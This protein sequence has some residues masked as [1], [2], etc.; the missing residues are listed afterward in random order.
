[1]LLAPMVI[2]GKK[3][4][5]LAL[6]DVTEWRSIQNA[7][8]N[9]HM[10]LEQSYA[11]T[12][13][14]WGRAMELRDFETQ[15]HMKRVTDATVNLALSMGVSMEEI[16]HI[17]HGAVLHDIGKFAIPDA[18]LLKPA[19]LTPDEWIIMKR[20][21]VYAYELLKPVNYLT[22]SLPIPYSHHEKWDG[23]GYPQALH[24]TQIP[25][26]ARIFAVVDVWDALRSDRPY[27]DGWQDE[28]VRAY[29]KENSGSHFDPEVVDCF[30]SNF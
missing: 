7:L 25:L 30:L 9:T 28:R 29:I 15:G 2:L 5:H 22:R 3:F 4:L 8:I 12:L 20:H 14:G 6:R 11:I 13:E 10:E 1:M 27:R 18:I 24:T 16:P 21:P 26:S 23:S 17:R 19:S